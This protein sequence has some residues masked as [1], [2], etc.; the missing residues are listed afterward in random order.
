M[1]YSKYFK[2]LILNTGMFVLEMLPVSERLIHIRSGTGKEAGISSQNTPSSLSSFASS[3]RRHHW[4]LDTQ[5]VH[6][7]CDISTMYGGRP[8]LDITSI[9][10]IPVCMAWAL[11]VTRLRPNNW[12]VG[13]RLVSLT[14][15]MMEQRRVSETP[16]RFGEHRYRLRLWQL[17]QV[18]SIRPLLARTFGDKLVV[19]PR[20]ALP[21]SRITWT[22][23]S[24][25]VCRAAHIVESHKRAYQLEAIR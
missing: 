13:A 18:G 9:P 3:L 5:N 21:V 24:L 12:V 2:P 1:K 20:F 14:L 22:L 7:T 15:S 23:P 25:F 19:L 8:R 11:R 6:G 10:G 16:S 4:I 17:F